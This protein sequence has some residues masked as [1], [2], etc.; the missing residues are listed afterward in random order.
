MQN[1]TFSPATAK[2]ATMDELLSGYEKSMHVKT[3]EEIDAALG[4]KMVQEVNL[5]KAASSMQMDLAFKSEKSLEHN[6]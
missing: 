1:M 5:V 3:E 6:G 2:V 4:A